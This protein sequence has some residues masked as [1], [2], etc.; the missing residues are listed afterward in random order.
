[1]AKIKQLEAFTK[2]CVAYKKL[3]VVHDLVAQIGP[4][5]TFLLKEVTFSNLYR[6]KQFYSSNFLYQHAGT[7]VPHKIVPNPEIILC[8]SHLW[9]QLSALNYLTDCQHSWYQN[10]ST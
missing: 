9:Q 4:K 10:R 2:I 1:M 7:I 8:D 5:W 6:Y 3:G